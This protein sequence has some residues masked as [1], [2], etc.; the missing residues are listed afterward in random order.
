M[1]QE[2]IKRTVEFMLEQQA[3]FAADFENLKAGRADNDDRVAKLEERMAHIE[4]LLT[5]IV[6]IMEKMSALQ[7]HAINN[8]STLPTIIAETDE[9]VNLLVNIFER[10]LS[11]KDP[12]LDFN[13]EFNQ[14]A[15][16][17][18]EVKDVE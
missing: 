11:E 6:S 3:Q 18:F 1:N 4:E 14:V 15:A 5:K 13:A 10:Y 12:L 16:T 8:V 17:E 2:I 7:E 9:R